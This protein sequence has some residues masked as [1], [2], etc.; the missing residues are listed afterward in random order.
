VFELVKEYY[1][2]KINEIEK[3]PKRMGGKTQKYSHAHSA[4]HKTHKNRK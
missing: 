4:N 2:L 3:I 1:E